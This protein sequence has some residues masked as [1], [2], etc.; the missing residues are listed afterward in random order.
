MA[1]PIGAM[2][3]LALY[4]WGISRHRTEAP[5]EQI[6]PQARVLVIRWYPRNRKRRPR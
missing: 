5:P 3:K 4:D 2:V 6:D 1:A